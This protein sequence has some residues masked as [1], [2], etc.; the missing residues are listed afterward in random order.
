M[1]KTRKIC[2]FALKAVTVLKVIL[3]AFLIYCAFFTDPYTLDLLFELS[4][5]AIP[6]APVLVLIL[7]FS[8]PSVMLRLFILGMFILLWIFCGVFFFI[9]F[10]KIWA[11]TVFI[12][13]ITFTAVLDFIASFLFFY[14]AFMSILVSGC[15]LAICIINIVMLFISRKD[16]KAKSSSLEE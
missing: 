15:V 5:F 3:F 10:K 11:K 7:P 1:I 14:T 2:F 13:L 4:P 6:T 9:S 12:S 8:I 16:K